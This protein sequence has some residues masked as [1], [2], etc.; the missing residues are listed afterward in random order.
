MR[1]APQ[2]NSLQATV[3]PGPSGGMDVRSPIGSMSPE[4]AI[5][6]YNMMPAEYGLLLRPG[7][8]EYCIGLDNGDLDG[9]VRTLIPFTG[10]QPG[11]ADDYLFAVTNEGMWNVT[12]YNNPVFVPEVVFTDTSSAAGHGVYCHFI[13][14]AGADL[15]YYA[16]SKNGLFQ[17]DGTT[18]SVPT[19]ITG[20]VISN[21]CFCMVHKQRIWFIEEGSSKG[22]YLEAGAIQGAATEFQFGPKFTH[23][24]RLYALFN[25]TVDG[26]LGVDDFL[27]AIST[28]GDVIVYQGADPS[29]ADT[30]ESRGVYYIGDIPEGRRFASEYSGDLYVLSAFGLISMS[31]LLKGVDSAN[32]A[33]GSLAFKIARPLR[34]DIQE[35]IDMLG[36]EPIFLPPLGQLLIT[37]PKSSKDR[38]WIQYGMNLAV[39]GWGLW[40]GVPAQ[41]AED[42]AGKVYFGTPDGRVCVMDQTVDEV[43]ITP[44]ALPEPN[45]NAIPFSILSSYT[46]MGT[47]AVFKRV[48]MLRPNFFSRTEPA[49]EV[50]IL[51]DYDYEEPSI[52]AEAPAIGQSTWDVGLWDQAIWYSELGTGQFSL[53]GV[54]G[55]GR[56]IAV[57][58]RGSSREPLRFISWDAM[59]QAGG[60]I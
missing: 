54:A 53:I 19:G 13:T 25:W 59:W 55:I 60:P 16:D 9:G 28:A 14:D 51:Y 4:D 21:I 33:E 38:E 2:Q 45:G 11:P 56:S 50:K 20:P 44:P 17:F 43:K 27:V 35:K 49:Y 3:L 26:G 42:F 7:Y 57:A 39:E 6:L 12:D 23:G 30:W 37:V 36:W 31:D 24:G 10:V 29:S 41:C 47:P 1:L 40:R 22:W 34:I 46:Y 48:Q 58:M 5:Y 15:L 32:P 8:R 52:G 18:W